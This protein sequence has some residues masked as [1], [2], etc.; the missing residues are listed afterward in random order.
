MDPSASYTSGFSDGYQAACDQHNSEILHPNKD[1]YREM[2]LDLERNKHKLNTWAVEF[3]SKIL[4][5]YFTENNNK[6]LTAK[7]CACIDKM[8]RQFC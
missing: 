8:Y 3:V 1:K 6:R 4:G 2:L 7:Q 5:T